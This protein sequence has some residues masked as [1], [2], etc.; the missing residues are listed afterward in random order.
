LFSSVCFLY[1][2]HC[3]I[4]WPYVAVFIY[5][6]TETPPRISFP[7]NERGTSIESICKNIGIFS[8]GTRKKKKSRNIEIEFRNSSFTKKNFVNLPGFITIN[9]CYVPQRTAQRSRLANLSHGS[10]CEHVTLDNCYVPQRATQRLRILY[11]Q[12]IRIS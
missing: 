7:R 6:K 4:P 9:S 1:V 12:K 8:I 5:F 10:E 11:S 2:P 3:Q